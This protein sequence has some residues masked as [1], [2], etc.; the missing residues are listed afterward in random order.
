MCTELQCCSYTVSF[1]LLL[2]VLSWHEA[3]LRL[4]KPLCPLIN[5]APVLI[6]RVFWLKIP[7][8]SIKRERAAVKSTTSLLQLLSY[9]YYNTSIKNP[10]H[11]NPIHFNPTSKPVLRSITPLI[12]KLSSSTSFHDHNYSQ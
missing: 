10:I 3:I 11:F 4:L 1:K 8:E 5:L 9:Y 7:I 12:E 2:L 6:L